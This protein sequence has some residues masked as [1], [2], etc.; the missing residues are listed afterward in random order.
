MPRKP[1]LALELCDKKL[2][3]WS[4]QFP[5]YEKKPIG[6]GD[7]IG[8]LVKAVSRVVKLDLLSVRESRSS[9]Q[10]TFLACCSSNHVSDISVQRD[11]SMDPLGSPGGGE[12][13]VRGY[14]LMRQRRT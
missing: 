13:R 3:V 4:R 10:R 9:F 14:C 12:Q 2:L 6:A 1:I 5:L 8:T 7:G 11:V